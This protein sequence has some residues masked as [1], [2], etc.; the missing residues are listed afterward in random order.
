[1][2]AGYPVVDI[3]V[4]LLDGSF[5]EVDSSEMAF[6]MAG[7]FAFKEGLQKGASTLDRTGYEG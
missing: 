6:K 5:H 7:T 3:N 2:V 4:T 1:M